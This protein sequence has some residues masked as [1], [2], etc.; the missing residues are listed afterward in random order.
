MLAMT[1]ATMEKVRS[2]W[3]V[4]NTMHVDVQCHNDNFLHFSLLRL[5]VAL[6]VTNIKSY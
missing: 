6:T 2:V 1:E 4:F 3:H 5:L